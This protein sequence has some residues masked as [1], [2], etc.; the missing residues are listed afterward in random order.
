MRRRLTVL[1]LAATA[2]L[3]AVPVPAQAASWV[4]ATCGAALTTNSYLRAD[5]TCVGPGLSFDV[6]GQSGYRTRS[7]VLDL[8]GH[9]LRAGPGSAGTA[10]TVAGPST[11]SVV[12]GTIEGWDV[13]LA[14]VA[15]DSG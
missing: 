13:G 5:L 1:V 10:V 9:T 2:G 15:G 12:N 6:R 8:R 7:M 14:T 4:A 11:V 3:A